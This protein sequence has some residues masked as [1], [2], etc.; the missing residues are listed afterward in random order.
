MDTLKLTVQGE[1]LGQITNSRGRP[2]RVRVVHF[3]G[4]YG[5]T[6]SLVNSSAIPLVEFYDAT[7]A[8]DDRFGPRGQFV[9]RYTLDMLDGTSEWASGGPIGETLGLNLAGG[10]DAWQLDREAAAAALAFAQSQI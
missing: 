10:E 2:F 4:R 1:Q 3:G 6:D 7:Y 8:G 5:Q 9:S